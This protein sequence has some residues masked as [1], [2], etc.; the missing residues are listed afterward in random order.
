[1]FYIQ[2][3]AAEELKESGTNYVFDLDIRDYNLWMLELMPVVLVLYDA[4]RRKAY[5][6]HVQDYF[7]RNFDRRPRMSAK[8]VRVSVT[9][10]RVFNRRAVAS[11]REIGLCS[12][13]WPL[14]P[15][16]SEGSSGFRAPFG[17]RS[18]QVG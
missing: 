18:R 17:G 12:S 7:R 1:M 9:K 10:R 2:G 15:Y 11:L 14:L 3:K 4:S 5:W 16:Q 6:L 13:I 8:T